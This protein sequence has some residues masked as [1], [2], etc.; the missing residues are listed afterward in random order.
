VS[1]PES[2]RPVPRTPWFLLGTLGLAVFASVSA[3][4]LPPALALGMSATL[5]VGP[6]QIGVLV[7]VWAVSVVV[8]TVPL[9]RLTA[10]MPRR[11]LLVASLLVLA[12]A[13]VVVA[14]VPSYPVVLVARAVSALGAA[15]SWSVIFGYVPA[16]V[17]RERLGRAMSVV[18]GGG[19]LASVLGVPLGAL[20]ASLGGWPFA[21]VGAAAVLAIAAGV[22]GWRLPALPGAS[23]DRSARTRLDRSFALVLVLLASGALLLT[24]YMALFA[25]IV[26]VAVDGAGIP[27]AAMSGVLLAAGLA[28]A[29]ALA[30]GG[31]VGDR[32]PRTALLAI[33]A[34]VPAGIGLVALATTAVA[35]PWVAV[36]G[37]T[38]IGFGIGGM[39]PLF[40]ARIVRVA[41]PATR[42]LATSLFAVV[43]NV[44]IAVGS[45]LGALTLTTLGVTGLGAVALAITT[46]ALGAFVVTSMTIP[47]HPG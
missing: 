5:G 20:L 41:S 16:L 24:G 17:P 11:G 31:A 27:D 36:A 4:L 39:P 34:A 30:V 9:V 18:L 33:V 43:L 7:T 22:A 35:A 28:G 6:A 12:A 8:G 46:A 29:G 38:L 37:T 47:D 21:F 32:W 10:R 40:Q 3:E 2:I 44:G 14:T 26:P 25:Y 15:L 13:S 45:A 19:T 1:T 42:E 23:R